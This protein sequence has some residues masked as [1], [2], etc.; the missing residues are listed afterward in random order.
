MSAGVRPTTTPGLHHRGT[1][2]WNQLWRPF[3]AL[4][5]A[6][7][8]ASAAL[9]LTLPYLDTGDLP[10]VFSGGADSARTVLS[11]I[12]GGMISLTGLVFSIT[13]VVLQQASSQFTPR[14]LRQFLEARVVQVTLG[15]FTGTFVYGLTVLRTVQSA[16]DGNDVTFVPQVSVTVAMVFVLVSVALF[17]AFIAYIMRSVQ[18]SQVITDLTRATRDVVLRFEESADAPPRTAWSAPGGARADELLNGDRQGYVVAIRADD[19]ARLAATHGVVVEL[20]LAIGQHVA[21]GAR[22]GRVWHLPGD[23]GGDGADLDGTDLAGL[24]D[25]VRLED[26]RLLTNDPMFGLRQLVDI[27]ERALSPGVN[28]PTTA[29]QVVDFAETVLR[30]AGSLADPAPVL[31]DDDGHP[32]VVYRPWTFER[33]LALAVDEISRYGGS[34][35]RVQ[36]SLHDLLTSIEPAVRT[37]HAVLVRRWIRELEAHNAPEDVDEDEDADA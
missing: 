14:I 34:S 20:E 36:R 2:W 6:L 27:A 19:L 37:E 7:I 35:P 21:P 32:R 31:V 15:V 25:A 11:S 17:I 16:N 29:V 5:A 33:M 12:I 24:R 26:D 22:L 18:V 1:S 23:G 30:A 13:M 10:Y 3:W 9:G 28:D 4:P 8:V